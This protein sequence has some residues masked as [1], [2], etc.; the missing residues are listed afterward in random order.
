VLLAKFVEEVDSP[1]KAVRAASALLAFGALSAGCWLA[2]RLGGTSEHE[3]S[4]TE[5]ISV[6]RPVAH[7]HHPRLNERRGSRSVT[8]WVVGTAVVVM[9]VVVPLTIVIAGGLWSRPAGPDIGHH[10]AVVDVDALRVRAG[11][12]AH[13][14][15]TDT[16][17]RGTPVVVRCAATAGKDPWYQL[18]DPRPGEYL[19]G[20]GLAFRTRSRLAAPRADLQKWPPPPHR[21][22]PANQGPALVGP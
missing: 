13:H 8:G 21:W 10:S 11:P 12:S 19:S 17:Y 15:Q 20:V 4:H 7:V 9:L 6:P 16:L 1:A 22:R 2:F 18:V 5:P 3:E 14:P